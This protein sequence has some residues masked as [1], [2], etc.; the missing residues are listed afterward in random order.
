MKKVLPGVATVLFAGVSCGRATIDSSPVDGQGALPTAGAS[1]TGGTSTTSSA[2]KRG[3]LD[4]A[5]TSAACGDLQHD[6]ELWRRALGDVDALTYT[7]VATDDA[8]DVF[9]ASPSAG[10]TKLNATGD[11]EW[12]KPF[13]SMVAAN[14]GTD[15]YLA[16]TFS[17]GLGVGS[18][19][20]GAIGEMDAYVVK[21]DASG[22]VLW[23]SALGASES[24]TGFAVDPLGRAVVSG[25][26]L[27]TVA[28]D[29]RGGVEWQRSLSGAVAMDSTGD[30]LVTG[31]LTGSADFD[32]EVL[33]SAGGEDVFVA[34]LDA[35]GNVV[36]AN[37]FG[38][39]GVNQTGQGIAVDSH[40][41]ILVSGV[42][43]GSIDFGGG[44]ITV[45]AHRCPEETWCKASGFIVKFDASGGYVWSRSRFPV[46]SLPG[47]ASDSK[48]EVLVSGAYPGNVPPYRLPLLVEFDSSGEDVARTVRPMS[49]VTD[50]GSGYGVA[51]DRCDNALWSLSAPPVPSMDTR[52]FLT[53]LTP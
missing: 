46:R 7:S 40:D 11:V 52:S 28:L 38:D 34:K 13:G 24:V 47:I 36:F 8:G 15:V 37:R 27:G 23:C 32:G 44:A 20:T 33:E 10:T 50:A 53:K 29:E 14:G 21:L 9:V 45:D 30:V 17:E 5:T 3:P 48:D 12:S 39:A 2:S 1:G 31:A 49:A 22:T 42:A 16:G 26:G 43:D 25:P 19:R 35:E 18:C 4:S 51:F 6:A 41:A